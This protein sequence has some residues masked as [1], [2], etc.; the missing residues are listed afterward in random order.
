M[1]PRTCRRG[2]TLVELLVVIGI[3]A[4]LIS[5]LLPALSRARAQANRIKC[6]SNMRQLGMAAV[7][8]SGAN[9]GRYPLQPLSALS[10]FLDDAVV[11]STNVNNRSALATL[12]SAL[13]GAKPTMLSC[14]NAA[15]GGW[16]QAALPTATSDTNYMINAAIIDQAFGKIRASSDIIFVQ[17]DRYRWRTAYLRP[18]RMAAVGGR[19]VYSQWC[20]ENLPIGQEYS[21]IHPDSHQQS[22]EG[23]LLY[24]DGH[25]ASRSHRS[26]HPTDFGLV[27]GTGVTGKDNDPNT[28]AHAT[29]YFFVYGN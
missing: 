16:N 13:P 15:G 14:P 26:L 10:N 28:V 27:G 9:K 5:I 11:N 18:S 24:C 8:Y 25:A 19:K 12:M 20:F 7:I 2:F 4:L 17:E 22:G 21:N 3:I 6:L 29:T 23:N 1:R